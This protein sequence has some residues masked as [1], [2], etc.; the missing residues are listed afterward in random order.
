MCSSKGQSHLNCYCRMLPLQCPSEY[1]RH[2][3]IPP[4]D[5]VQWHHHHWPA[6]TIYLPVTFVFFLLVQQPH[7]QFETCGKR[8]KT[9]F[10][11]P[12]TV[13]F[14]ALSTR[15]LTVYLVFQY[16]SILFYLVFYFSPDRASFPF[17]AL[18]LFPGLF[19]VPLMRMTDLLSI[20]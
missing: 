17:S 19:T 2:F 6:I 20:L 5:I 11:P 8:V 9:R 12:L 15:A 14:S 3:L 16:F 18:T 10:H 1:Q 4:S 13:T 7:Q